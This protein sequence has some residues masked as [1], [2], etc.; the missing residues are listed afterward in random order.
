MRF[1]FKWLSYS[2]W[3]TWELASTIT[4]HQAVI[5]HRQRYECRCY[6]DLRS[7]ETSHCKLVNKPVKCRR[8]WWREYFFQFLASRRPWF[9]THV[10]L[11]SS[12]GYWKKFDY[13]YETPREAINLNLDVRKRKK[14]WRRYNLMNK[15]RNRKE[16]QSDNTLHS[17]V[18]N[19]HFLVKYDIG[20]LTCNV[21]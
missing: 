19:C 7:Q 16:E 1:R 8:K 12:P 11:Q 5:F 15:F 9:T 3:W 2:T 6:S 21:T 14:K 18:L 20:W 17:F 4:S 13:L 10:L